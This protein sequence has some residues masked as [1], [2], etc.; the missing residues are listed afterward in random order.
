VGGF[1]SRGDW[2]QR[3]CEAAPLGPVGVLAITTLLYLLL[4][5]VFDG[6]L[7]S[8]PAWAGPDGPWNPREL[9]I[10]SVNGVLIGYLLAAHAVARRGAFADLER[11][12]PAL[13]CAD[14]SYGA[15][16]RSIVAPGT[17]VSLAAAAF[18]AGFSLL[19]VMFDP[20]M[21]YERSRPAFPDP[22]LFWV[23]FRNFAVGWVGFRLGFSEL[24]MIRGF[25]RLGAEHARVD[26][27]D[28]RPLEPFVRKGQR[29][30]VIWILFSSILSLFWIEGSA[31]SAN[32]FLLVLV[33]GLATVAFL[34]PLSAVR[35]RIVAAKRAELARVNE[36][37][38][39]ERAALL[40]PASEPAAAHLA[41]LIA[42]RGLV[43]ATHEWPL[44]T[45]ALLRFLLFVLLG[46]AS[47]LGGALVER[48]LDALLG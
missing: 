9:F 8:L 17:W 36:A 3:L 42:W 18:A 14:A 46:L 30:V 13:D 24:V 32:P 4:S 20:A 10:E 43:E 31:A 44:S 38:W 15:W 7:G 19:V 41:N 12:R 48:A 33:L 45:P 35:R 39:R 2:I 28:T 27:L 40:D 16:V 6:I 5:F 25:S 34:L 37:L 1:R 21:W 26:L 11:L 47:W 23:L 22:L 29:S